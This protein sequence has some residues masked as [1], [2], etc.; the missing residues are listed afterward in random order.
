LDSTGKWQLVAKDPK[1]EAIKPKSSLRLA[2]TY[3]LKARGIHYFITAD[4]SPGAD[5]YRDDPAAWGLT[6]AASGYGI[7]IYRVTL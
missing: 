2:A 3:E 5:D 4:D 6:Q 7:R 1:V